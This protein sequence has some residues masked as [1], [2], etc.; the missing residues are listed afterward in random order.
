MYTAKW[1][2]QALEKHDPAPAPREF[3]PNP[4]TAARLEAVL[5]Q[6]RALGCEVTGHVMADDEDEAAMQLRFVVNE[7]EG[8][9]G[10]L[11]HVVLVNFFSRSIRIRSEDDEVDFSRSVAAG[12]EA[13]ESGRL[14]SFMVTWILAAL[15]QCAEAYREHYA[16]A[17]V[18]SKAIKTAHAA[19]LRAI[20]RFKNAIPEG[21]HPFYRFSLERLADRMLIDLAALT[22][23]NQ[24]DD[25][26]ELPF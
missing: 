15:H 1:L 18:W 10:P 11:A 13:W 24:G 8:G 2:Q 20:A 17:T 21:L 6:L 4:E 5:I 7:Q 23:V 19:D 14:S 26:V 16:P 9:G 22:E 12:P 25:N 3:V